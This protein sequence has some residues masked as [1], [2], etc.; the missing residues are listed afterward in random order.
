[1]SD[2]SEIKIIGIEIF[3]PKPVVAPY[4]PPV[5][6][7]TDNSSAAQAELKEFLKAKHAKPGLLARLA[8]LTTRKPKPDISPLPM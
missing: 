4:V 5:M 2:G 7:Q 3:T 8:A 6:A 1:M